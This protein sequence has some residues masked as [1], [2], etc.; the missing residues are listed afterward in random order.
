[1]YYVYVLKSKKNQK[2]YTGFTTTIPQL[3]CDQHNLGSN[4]YTR[5][6][7]P[8]ELIYFEA[9]EDEYFARRRE[10]FLK[11]GHGRRFLDR[12]LSELK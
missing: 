4:D 5:R 7:R 10:R 2:R 12:K 9:Y 11:T 6:N 3:R 1:M 8:F